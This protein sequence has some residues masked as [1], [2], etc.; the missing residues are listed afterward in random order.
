MGL[1]YALVFGI[2][3]LVTVQI[4]LSWR[5]LVA[6]TDVLAPIKSAISDLAAAVTSETTVLTNVVAALQALAGKP[7]VSP[8]DVQKLA[9]GIEASVANLNAAATAANT[10]LNPPT[11]APTPAPE[12]TPAP[13]EPPVTPPTDQPPTP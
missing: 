9:D 1:E 3:F 11:P 2:S 5:I 4:Y 13:T 10:V 8:A 12:P 7:Q 6:T